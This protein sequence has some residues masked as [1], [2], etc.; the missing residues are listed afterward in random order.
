MSRWVEVF[1]A[2][3]SSWKICQRLASLF[4]WATSS[5]PLAINS[6]LSMQLQEGQACAEST[7][8]RSQVPALTGCSRAFCTGVDI[9][10]KLPSLQREGEESAASPLAIYKCGG[11]CSSYAMGRCKFNLLATR[12]S[13]TRSCASS[14]CLASV[15]QES[16]VE[17]VRPTF[18][19]LMLT[20]APDVSK[21]SQ[22][23]AT[24][25]AC[26]CLA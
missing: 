22:P 5:K 12:C 19:K 14:F 15:L 20:H 13:T 17:G 23:N 4:R 6:P 3:S 9:V 16:A 18:R 24:C 21:S 25:W 26:R 2:S 11:D 8:A 1:E 7:Y 10:M